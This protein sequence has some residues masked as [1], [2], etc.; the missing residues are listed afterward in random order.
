[1]F[2]E[3]VKWV[4]ESTLPYFLAC[5]QDSTCMFIAAIGYILFIG[6]ILVFLKC[7]KGLR[8]IQIIM[9]I[10]FLIVTLQFL[11]HIL[12]ERIIPLSIKP[13]VNPIERITNPL[14]IPFVILAFPYLVYTLI[15]ERKQI[16]KN[17]KALRNN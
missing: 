5:N 10:C 4:N 2:I 15:K 17:I 7:F 6:C 3:L 8:I 1:M 12:F 14:T 13:I 16:K 9:I 11:E